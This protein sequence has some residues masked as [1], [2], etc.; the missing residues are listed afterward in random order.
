MSKTP[1]VE[2]ITPYSPGVFPSRKSLLYVW[3]ATTKLYLTCLFNLS[4]SFVNM[5]YGNMKCI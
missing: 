2:L 4:E 1:I 3:L 5:Q